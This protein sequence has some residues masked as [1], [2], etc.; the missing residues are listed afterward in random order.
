[1]K[2]ELW[3]GRPY[4]LGA[5]FDGYGTNFS[6]FSE[7][8]ERIELC[9]FHARGREERIPLPEVTGF[10]WHGY[11]PDVAPGTRYGFRVHGP[12]R[13]AEGLRCNPHKLLLDPYAMTVV[14]DLTWD[15]AVF[16]YRFGDADGA[17]NTKNSA[18]HVPRGVVTQPFFEWGNDRPPRTPWNETVIYEAHVRGLTMRHPDVPEHQ[19]G[20]YSGLAHPAVI[21]HLVSLGVTAIELLPVHRFVSEHHLIEQGLSDYW[22]YNSIAYLAPHDAYASSEAER[23]VPEFKRMVRTLH[24]AGIEV[25]LDVVYNHTAEGNHLG[26]TLSLKGFDN[27]AYY[28]LVDDDPRYYMDYTGTGNSMNMRHPHVLQLIMD[29]LRY[30][31]QEMHVDGFRFDLASALA[32]ELHD[33]D[34]LST[35][36]EVIQQDPVISQT[37]LI[38]EPWDVGEGGYQVGNF[39]PLWSEWNGRY[40][41]TVRDYWR[42]ADQTLPEFASRFT[43]SSDLYQSDR[44][45][46]SASINFVTAHDGFT[47][48]DLVS[49]NSK[50]NEANGEG[51]RDGTDD[52]RSWNCGVEGETAD[53]EV[54]TLRARQQRN[55]LTTLMLSQGVPMLVAGDEL[56]RTQ[57]GN[58]NGYAQDNEL[59]WLDWEEV[60]HDLRE[61]TRQLI[62]LRRNH[63]VFRRRRFFEGKSARGVEFAD[64]AWL[65]PDGQLMSDE[66][67][68]SRFAKSLQIVLNG[69]GITSTDDR[70]QVVTDQSFLLLYNA[71]HEPLEFIAPPE[72]PFGSWV[73]V[74]DT[75]EP[76]L[77]TESEFHHEVLPPGEA[78]VVAAYAMVVARAEA[79]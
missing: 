48:R 73:V 50:H 14:G 30:W 8:A 3:P 38:A 40:R 76:Q 55:I 21:E 34:R 37:K 52:N 31:V 63:P 29:S 75:T 58:N 5:T 74:L 19:R 45:R 68:T 24:E 26:P 27:Q 10:V 79:L 44:R 23:V 69:E 62:E 16:G 46:P 42:G 4:P 59:S 28:R 53:L 39:P 32:R 71:H 67:W 18:R 33:V 35:F 41:D 17:M 22:G 60:D 57:R 49:Y 77:R 9:I 25:I 2:T 65:T 61:F 11:A 70:G 47:L 7:V 54:L 43:G 20:T 12:Y 72:G 66:H 78:R 13:P 15:E 1:M 6:V 36:F 64:I 56:G 51:N